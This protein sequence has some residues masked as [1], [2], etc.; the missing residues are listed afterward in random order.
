M[1][2]IYGNIHSIESC[3][4]V[5]G[6]G[7]RFVIFTQGCPLR[8]Q[9][10]H[11]P[12]SWD[13]KE[14]QKMSVEEILEQYEGVKEFCTGGV[15][16]T[17]GEPMAQM[18][19][20]TELFKTFKEKGIHTAL[21]TSGLYFN[22]ENTEKVDELLKYTDL[23]LLDIKHIDNEEHIKLTKHSNKNILD[24]AKYLSEINKP[25]WI[26][27]VVVPGITF[28][29]EYLT[30]LGQFL[31]GLHNIKALDVLPYHDMAIPKYENLGIDYPLKGVPPLTHDEA[32]KA[33]NIIIEA[34][35]SEREKINK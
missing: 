14:N 8:C 33:R 1:T 25:V 17:G 26:R 6:P 31:A 24:F 5:Y 13:F 19:F 22:R 16:V 29:E 27:H 11:N 12:D 20:V 32:K 2:E 4:T 18:D 30:R 15:T 7:I 10:C 3:G 9:Y 21:D 34:L 28:K 23:V 35:K